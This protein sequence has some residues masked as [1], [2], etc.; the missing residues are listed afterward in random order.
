MKKTLFV[1]F[2]TILMLALSIGTAFASDKQPA[3]NTIGTEII[4]YSAQEITDE[5]VLL[6]RAVNGISD[7]DNETVAANIKING[8]AIITDNV[9]STTQLLSIKQDLLGS[10][11]SEYVTTI[12]SNF[13]FE[14]DDNGNT[15]LRGTG[16]WE[17]ED[18]NNGDATVYAKIYYEE[19][20]IAGIPCVK[21]QKVQGG[22]SYVESNTYVVETQVSS[23]YRGF[24]T[25]PIEHY[26]QDNNTSGSSNHLT[27]TV[28]SP[29]LEQP[30]GAYFTCYSEVLLQR[31]TGQW[32]VD[33]EAYRSWFY[34]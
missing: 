7:V 23:N 11:T 3:N 8:E 6:E 2:A 9:C 1:M 4:L 22:T 26:D 27:L 19:K 32:S 30:S 17:E 20:D 24:G 12:I 34:Y 10:E 31:G 14:E 28:N 29:Y 21:L 16:V 25:N 18:T 13:V 5:E 33:V 15:L